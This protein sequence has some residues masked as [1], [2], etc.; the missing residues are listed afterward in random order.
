MKVMVSNFTN[1]FVLGLIVFSSIYVKSQQTEDIEAFNSESVNL[2][3]SHSDLDLPDDF[4]SSSPNVKDVQVFNTSE[5]ILTT[6]DLENVNELAY[7]IIHFTFRASDY[8]F[9]PM[10][11]SVKGANDGHIHKLERNVTHTITWHYKNSNW[12]PILANASN[13]AIVDIYEVKAEESR[14]ARRLITKSEKIE[15]LESKLANAKGIRKWIL[16]KRISR[17]RNKVIPRL[18]KR[19]SNKR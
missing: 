14:T 18:E 19:Y 4:R 16:T 2:R 15:K 12:R 10:D 7:Y 9:S 5:G 11:G 6:F 3:K 17:L 1:F 13:E 8:E